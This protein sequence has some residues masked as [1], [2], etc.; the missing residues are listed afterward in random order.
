ML[1]IVSFKTK[2]LGFNALHF[3]RKFGNVSINELRNEGPIKV[4]RLLRIIKGV[5][6]S[7]YH[8]KTH[9][10]GSS[11]QCTFRRLTDSA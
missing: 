10:Q 6:L 3:K 7:H 1:S 5:K 8:D 4:I 9:Q 2:K 11:K